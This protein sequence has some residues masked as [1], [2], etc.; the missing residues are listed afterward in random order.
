MVRAKEEDVRDAKYNQARIVVDLSNYFKKNGN[1][2]VNEAWKGDE[3][4]RF[5]EE[6]TKMA[7]PWLININT[8]IFSVGN[9]INY[10][11]TTMDNADK[12]A[13][14]VA[15]CLIDKFKGIYH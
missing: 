7:R 2:V 6:M 15:S 11:V 9:P 3:V 5:V 14:K 8:S 4:N 1:Q 10:A 12:K 13:G